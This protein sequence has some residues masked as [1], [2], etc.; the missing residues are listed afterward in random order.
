MLRDSVGCQIFV[1]FLIFN[2]LIGGI[3]FDYSL[4]F[5]FGKDIP[6]WGDVLCGLVT[7]EFVAPVAI[8][9]F[10]LDIFMDGPL[11]H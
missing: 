1:L 9:C 3:C 10:V 4:N 2:L 8:V 5:I 7:A 11:I 6:W